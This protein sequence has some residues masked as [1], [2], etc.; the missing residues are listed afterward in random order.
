MSTRAKIFNNDKVPAP[1]YTL[2]KT[3]LEQV[4]D[5]KYLGVTMQQ[6]LKSNKHIEAKITTA[7]KQLRMIKRALYWAPQS[8]KLLKYKSLCISHLEYEAE[9]WDTSNEG[10]IVSLEQVQ[11]Q[12]VR[13]VAEI[14]DTRGISEAA[15][16][17]GLLP[18]QQRRNQQRFSLLMRI[19][20]KE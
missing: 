5:S 3:A 15:E 16:K 14:K 10:E 8:A 4:T 1:A 20:N 19:L 2:N 18:P 7:K 12:T 9:A 17:L 13:F 6:D 11:N